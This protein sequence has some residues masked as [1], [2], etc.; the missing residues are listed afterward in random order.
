[1][2][3]Y[4]DWGALRHVASLLGLPSLSVLCGF[5]ASGLPVGLQ[6]PG[7]HHADFAALQLGHAFDQVTSCW[8]QRPPV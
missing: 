4:V 8:R 1:M 7:R 3:T 5:T 2:Y 6:I